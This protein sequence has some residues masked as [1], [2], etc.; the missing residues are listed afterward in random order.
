[1]LGMAS[2]QLQPSPCGRGQ[3]EGEMKNAKSH[4][5]DGVLKTLAHGERVG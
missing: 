5:G 4:V 3:G 1:M 2:F